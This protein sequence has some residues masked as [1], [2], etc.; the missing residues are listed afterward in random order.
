MIVYRII[1]PSG[2]S[3]IGITSETLKKRW[4][5]HVRAAVKNPKPHPFRDAIR[6][7][8][9][10]NFALEVLSENLSEDDAK[11]LEIAFISL[12]DT[13]NREHG[14]N[15]SA[16]G[17][18][19]APYATAAAWA[20]I[21]RTPETRAAYLK[22][23]SDTKKANDW[24]NYA[25]LTEAVLKWNKEHPEELKEIQR[26][27]MVKYREWRAINKEHADEQSKLGLLKARQSIAD[28]Y[29]AFIAALTA[30][31]RKS[32]EDPE[33][34]K[35]QSEQMQRMWGN[36]TPENRVE[37]GKNVSRGQKAA[38]KNMPLEDK[39]VHDAQLAE[40]RKN[41]DHTVRK[42]WQKEALAA[43]WTPERRAEKA[44]L[45]KEFH[46]KKRAEANK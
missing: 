30:G 6:K 32:F 10:E 16:G 46:A 25:E 20:A 42:T 31:I 24:T 4:D 28:D 12:F 7:Y 22:K 33:R 23:L 34:R 27:R 11:A 41:I 36:M 21:N 26:E 37:H 1:S 3:Y 18:Y 39:A 17:D 19:D 13:Q 14:Y 38:Y 5:N 9:K 43:Y 2:K 45:W 8:G 44:I 35:N 29:P 40:A 15:I